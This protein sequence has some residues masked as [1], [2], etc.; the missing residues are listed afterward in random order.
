MERAYKILLNAGYGIWAT[1][2]H[3]TRSVTEQSEYATYYKLWEEAG[4]SHEFQIIDGNDTIT[5][6]AYD[7]HPQPRFRLRIADPKQRYADNTIPIYAIA[8]TSHARF[9]LYSYM[10]N[11]ILTPY[12]IQDT[13]RI[14]YVDTDSI[15]CSQHLAEFLQPCIGPELDSLRLRDTTKSAIGWLPN[16]TLQYHIQ[17]NPLRN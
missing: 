12:E 16:H 2:Q 7:A 14:Y 15:F 3:T 17:A 9:T 10:L 1:R 6:L 11:G 5:V 8:T 13:H 4:K